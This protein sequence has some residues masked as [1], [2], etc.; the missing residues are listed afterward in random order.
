[1]INAVIIEDD[2]LF[3]E[4]FRS[5]VEKI[6]EEKNLDFCLDCLIAP[7]NLEEM[8]KNYDIYFFDIEL[9]T[10]S[11]I[12]L[13]CALR[14]KYIEKDFIFVSNYEKYLRGCMKAKPSAF[15]RKS[16]LEKDL[17]ETFETMERL[18]AL[19][20]TE[21]ILKNNLSD[22]T[23]QISEIMYIYS[24]EHYLFLCKANGTIDIIRNKMKT[25]AAQL[26]KYDFLRISHRFLINLMY[27]EDFCGKSVV[28]KDGR[29][30]NVTDTYY[31]EAS[32]VLHNWLMR[33][34]W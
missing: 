26:Q 29:G 3:A 34:F 32:E 24:R 33:G 13:A 20:E 27:L 11:G 22:Y 6:T 9:E 4:Y 2:T 7:V 31:R 18:F 19:K 16:Y 12:D 30:I 28:M 23:V 21:I 17:R 5:V 15:V 14:R 10:D 1:M 8:Q 25:V